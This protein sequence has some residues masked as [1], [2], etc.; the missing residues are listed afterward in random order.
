MPFMQKA[1]APG[2][3]GPPAYGRARATLGAGA[4]RLG[5]QRPPG[6]GADDH[7][8]PPHNA[9]AYPIGGRAEGRTGDAKPHPRPTDA[10]ADG[11][12]RRRKLFQ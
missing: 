2:G 1:P 5:A 4:S 9:D 8:H 10:E 3:R 12:P 6:A 11:H 7:H